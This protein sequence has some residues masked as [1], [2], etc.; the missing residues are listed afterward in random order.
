ME[1]EI[2][3][4][5]ITMAELKSDL[6]YI[7]QGLIKND[8][9]NKQNALDHKEIIVKIDHLGDTFQGKIQDKADQ[10]EV[11]TKFDNLSAT[12]ITKEEFGPI[13]K[14]AYGM[15]GAIVLAFLYAL[16]ESVLK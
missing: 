12:F 5:K 4:L 16:I 1:Q 10:R 3:N 8:E 6:S 14:I 11:M 13:K 9:A 15:V 7:K 2:S